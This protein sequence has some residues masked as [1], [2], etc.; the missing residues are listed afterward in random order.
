[1]LF[2]FDVVP[3]CGLHERVESLLVD[4][5]LLGLFCWLVLLTFVVAH[6]LLLLIVSSN[7][8]WL[9]PLVANVKGGFLFFS[10]LALFA[11]SIDMAFQD[12]VPVNNVLM[13]IFEKQLAF[14]NLRRLLLSRL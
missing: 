4:D 3:V 1:M 9:R 2:V 5:Q 10:L 13:G 6:R 14:Q 12:V 8:L 11:F 7:N